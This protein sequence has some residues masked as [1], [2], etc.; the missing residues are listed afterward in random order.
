[1]SPSRRD[2]LRIAG[3]AV[4]I[5]G[6]SSVSRSFDAL[7]FA[8][9]TSSFSQPDV[10]TSS[11]G[12]LDVELVA[13]PTKVAFGFGTRFA[14]TYN[15]T[16][17]GP[18]LRVRPGDVL[19]ITLENRLGEMTN[20]HTHG[21]HVS[22][23]G[24]ADNIFVS[25][26]DRGRRVYRY[27]IPADHR[28][29]TFW[30]H[31][32]MHG[33]VARQ[34]FAGLAGAII[35]VDGID[36]AP[37][38]AGATERLLVL[39]D[40]AIG[41]SP[42]LLDVSMM[43]KM[44]GREG[45]DVLVNGVAMPAIAVKAGTLEHW[46]V[47]NA[48]PSRYYR[49]ALGSQTLHMIGTDG[50]RLASPV[51]VSDVLLAPGERVE[52]LAA[53]NQAGSYTL[54]SLPYDRGSTGMGSASGSSRR[55]ALATV[56]VDG[57]ASPAALP[58]TLAAPASLLLPPATARRELRLEM[59]MGMGGGNGGMGNGG[60]GAPQGFTINGKSFDASRT[61][62]RTSLSRVEDWKVTNTSPMDHPFHLHVWPFQ[63]VAQSSG[64]P[65]SPGWKDTV[66]VPAGESVTLRVPLTEISGRTVYHCHI[67]DHEDLGMMGVID[68]N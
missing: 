59:G 19:S 50:G 52:L 46:R 57:D 21:L 27:Q 62:I 33:T 10:L 37:A 55:T 45:G 51:E 8:A 14:Y 13:A 34:V 38:L 5:G 31:P 16:T 44:Q 63:V 58:T 48:S 54:R 35:V 22:P 29:G 1:M 53:L 17:P 65:I 39:S 6:L 56:T 12:R 9:P 47:L 68:V 11:N 7:G 26:P 64:A 24:A 42:A 25:V 66:N 41:S 3:G 32:H 15:G 43:Q 23:S 40:P 36:D 67:L 4:A 49:I 28:S 60:G 18:T 61:N 2:F 20:L 30:Y